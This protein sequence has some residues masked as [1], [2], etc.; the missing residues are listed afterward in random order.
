MTLP[1]WIWG[2]IGAIM[3]GL[4]GLVYK[5]MLTKSE[6]SEVCKKNTFE[7][8]KTVEKVIKDEIGGI[9]EYFDLKIENVVM[10]ELRKINHGRP[11]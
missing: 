1:E 3:M 5:S 8:N 9:K 2:L 7:V 6:H 4:I 11:D 10:K